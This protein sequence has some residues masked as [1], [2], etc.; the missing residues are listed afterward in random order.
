MARSVGDLA[1]AFDLLQGFD[2]K[3]PVSAA[4]APAVID[5][6]TG[7]EGIRIAIAGD[8]FRQGGTAAAHE[9]VDQVAGALGTS[10]EATLPQAAVARAS[11]YL[12]ANGE[13]AAFH[14]DRLR[15]QA[16]DFDVDT[17]YRFLS[18][19]CLPAAW[20]IKAQR[21]RRWFQTQAQNLFRD[22]DVLLAPATPC[23]APKSGEK[24]LQ[25]GDQTVP[26]RP[27]LGIF[28]QPISFIGLPSLVVP[29][30]QSDGLPLGVQ[31]IA[32]PWRED[33]LLRVAFALE[34][35]GV[36][37]APVARV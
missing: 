20:T 19:A 11:A 17:R 31:L 33:L 36:V 16:D 29:L 37:R 26:L 15:N 22:I 24:W 14:F 35:M 34:A 3:D 2:A 5:L 6:T 21:F 13:G 10:R 8:Y 7:I 12:I 32:A 1:L 28:T 25:L 9:A 18:G 30:P 4:K 23:S 27:N